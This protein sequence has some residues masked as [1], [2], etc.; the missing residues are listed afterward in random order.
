MISGTIIVYAVALMLISYGANNIA[1]FIRM[2]KFENF[3][4]KSLERNKI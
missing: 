3:I 1:G 4:R 2:K